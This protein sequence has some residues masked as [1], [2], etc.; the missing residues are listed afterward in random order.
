MPLGSRP[1]PPAVS[2][3]PCSE[4]TER[5]RSNYL[6]H[7]MLIKK[8]STGCVLQDSGKET[9]SEVGYSIS[10][11]AAANCPYTKS[12]CEQ[13]GSGQEMWECSVT[14]RRSSAIP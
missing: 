8:H 14:G 5:P 7:I 11:W 12:S 13:N 2:D 6:S 1:V 9:A 10:R 4:S 3:S